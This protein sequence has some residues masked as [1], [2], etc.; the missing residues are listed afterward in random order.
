MPHNRPRERTGRPHRNQ[1]HPRAATPRV[2]RH[3]LARARA[4]TAARGG[5]RR[6]GAHLADDDGSADQRAGLVDV[7]VQYVTAQV[8]GTRTEQCEATVEDRLPDGT[9][10]DEVNCL[11]VLATV[12]S[13][14]Q[15]GSDVE[16][17]ATATLTAADVPDG[18]RIVVQHYPAADGAPE[19]WAWP[20][21]PA[22]CRW[23]TLA[24]AFARRHRAGRAVGAGCVRSIGLGLAFVVLGQYVLPGLVAG[25]DAVSWRCAGPP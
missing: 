24:L 15:S 25:E 21:S 17:W 3:A 19:A 20:T 22:A 13:G 6:H 11:Q 1:A 4:R 5:G 2:A 7:D 8:T 23:R 12:T 18:T 10:P 9:V 16:V 14:A